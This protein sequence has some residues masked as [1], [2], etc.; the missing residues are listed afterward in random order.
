MRAAAAVATLIAPA[1]GAISAAE[2]GAEKAEVMPT[3]ADRTL[4]LTDA[5]LLAK[6]DAPSL[7][8][9]SPS[10]RSATLRELG[11]ATCLELETPAVATGG[12]ADQQISQG[13]R[14]L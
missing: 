11:C 3:T 2:E 9:L 7:L 5:W 12:L 14:S 6:I 13:A 1:I 4:A 10:C 8:A